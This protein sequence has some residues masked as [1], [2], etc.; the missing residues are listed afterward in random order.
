MD[1]I[2]IL[3]SRMTPADIVICISTP[4]DVK[5]SLKKNAM[6]ELRRINHKRKTNGER[7][8]GFRIEISGRHQ[9]KSPDSKS[10]PVI[11]LFD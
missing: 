9:Q 7:Q 8:Y 2:K 1:D 11:R 3:R 5:K 10:K 6:M 4:A